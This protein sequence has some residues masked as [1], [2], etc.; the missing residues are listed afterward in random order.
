MIGISENQITRKPLM[1]AVELVSVL[2]TLTLQVT[3][4]FIQTQA[5]AKAISEKDFV[6]AMLLRDPEFKD[7]LDAFIITSALDSGIKLPASKVCH[8]FPIIL[9]NLTKPS[10]L[11]ASHW[12]H[13]VSC[14]HVLSE[15]LALM[16]LTVWV[17]PLE[18]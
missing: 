12:Y 13:S 14:A 15:D 11:E 8:M 16:T 1:K 9:N 10:V 6:K 17:P 3:H 2:V 18:A 5:V 7:Y 4:W